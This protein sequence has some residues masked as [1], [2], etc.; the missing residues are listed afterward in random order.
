MIKILIERWDENKELLKELLPTIKNLNKWKY[1]HLVRFVFDIIYN[2]TEDDKAYA[3][4]TSRIT[5]ID[6]GE[7]KGTMVYLIPF[8]TPTPSE[9]DYLMTFIGYG[10]CPSCDVLEQAREEDD[11]EQQRNLYMNICKDIVANA[12]K[13]YNH[14]WRYD[15]RFDDITFE[16]AAEIQKKKGDGDKIPISSPKEKQETGEK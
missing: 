11:E 14:G 6:D 1:R 4:D 3:L 7:E 15:E 10:S 8:E 12:I 2:N 5:E 13:P 9:R 16:S